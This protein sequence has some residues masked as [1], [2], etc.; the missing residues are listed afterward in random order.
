MLLFF[1]SDL[2]SEEDRQEFTAIYEKYHDRMET[3]AIRMLKEQ[4]DAE[5]AVQNAFL[6]VINHFSKIYEIPCEKIPFWLISIVKNEALMILRKR[7]RIVPLE[8][9]DGFVVSAEGTTSYQEIVE[10]FRRL[11]RTYRA[12]LEMKILLG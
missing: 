3:V 12:T 8:D 1:L 11:P 5:D 10:L 9:W 7:N 4:K 2:Q 6:Q